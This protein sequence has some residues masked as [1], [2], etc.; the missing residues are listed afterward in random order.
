MGLKILIIEDESLAAEKLIR[1]LK[2]LDAG[3]EIMASVP[4]IASA[5][6]FL[7]KEAP[8]L[9]FSDI[10]L[11]DGL[12]FQLFDR[13]K[14]DIPVIFTTAYDQYAIQAFKTNSI[15][16]LLK[17]IRKKALEEALAKFE[18]LNKD[19]ATIPVDFAQMLHDFLP[20]DPAYKERFLVQVSG[21]RVKSIPVEEIAYFFAD[22]KHT[23]I[24][25][26]EGRT[27]FSDLNISH[28]VPEL[29]PKHFFQ[30]NRKFIIHIN[31]IR[32]MVHYS[33]SRLKIEL[34]PSADQEVIVS[35]E[36]SPAFKKWLGK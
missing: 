1:Q 28:L 8:E 22:G 29:N 19:S 2:K 15:D 33:K 18:R 11:A 34:N 6:N 14:T 36:R 21:G 12:S 7:E 31:S 35:V 5:M 24:V 27:H 26:N 3:I 13:I 23:F 9:I 25:T 10:H 30:V 4:S 17:P 32:E 20:K 16:Y